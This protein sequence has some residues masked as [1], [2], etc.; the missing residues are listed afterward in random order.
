M[1]SKSVLAAGLA[2]ALGLSGCATMAGKRWSYCAVAGGIVGAA[3]GAGTA[4]GLVN[5]YEG[6]DGGSHEE[7]GAAAG[8]GAVAGAIVGTLLGHLICDPR[9]RHRRLLRLLH[10]PPPP[11]PTPKKMSMSADA[12]F[13]FNKATLKPAGEDKVDEIV[14]TLKT[15]SRLSVLVEGHPTPSAATPTTSASPSGAPRPCAT[16]WSRK[17][18]TPRASRPAAT[19]NPSPSPATRPP[20][21]TPR[22]D[23]SKSP[24]SKARPA[25]GRAPL[26]GRRYCVAA[27]AAPDRLAPRPIQG[28]ADGTHLPVVGVL[29][30]G[31]KPEQ[32]TSGSSTVPD[33]SRC[34]P[35]FRTQPRRRS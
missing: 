19:A 6:G 34:R 33:P 10:H 32:V 35:R 17:A 14:H 28:S 16:T 23:A 30:N 15:D 26:P 11:A 31:M 7:T 20:K 13:D 29:K 27:H 24:N 1:R 9:S 18:S 22:T 8:G 2:L 25:T 21:D 4:G 3:A 12:F 5:A